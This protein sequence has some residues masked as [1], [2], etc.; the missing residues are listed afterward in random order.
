MSMDTTKVREYIIVKN[1]FNHPSLEEVNCYE[2]TGDLVYVSEVCRM[3]NEL[4][5]MDR[6]S[7]E[8][9]YVVALDHAKN[10]KGVCRIGHG[11]TSEV[12]MSMQSI[13]SFLLLS[14]A[15]SFYVV[16]NHISDM[17]NASEDDKAVTLKVG[18]LTNMFGNLTFNGHIIIN[19]NGYIVDGGEMDGAGKE[20]PYKD[21]GNGMAEY[22]VFGEKIKGT[23][24]EAKRIFE[25]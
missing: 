8:M 2:W 22:Y 17:P 15:N 25:D 6:L 12:L 14:G 18:L 19:P 1:E 4:F 20:L 13:F 7:T 16:H 3:L 9:S 5:R 10:L 11:D 21:L 23:L 24:E